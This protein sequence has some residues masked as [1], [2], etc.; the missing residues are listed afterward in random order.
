M[1]QNN[2][3][4]NKGPVGSDGRTGT[5]SEG[6]Q[7]TVRVMVRSSHYTHD[8]LMYFHTAT[9]SPCNALNFHYTS[10]INYTRRIYFN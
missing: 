1:A 3:S 2:I 10:I 4:P 8:H 5:G 6:P 7:P 9:I